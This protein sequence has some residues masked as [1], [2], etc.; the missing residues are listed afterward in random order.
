MGEEHIVYLNGNGSKVN[1]LAI[2][3][4]RE[5]LLKNP[6]GAWDEVRSFLDANAKEYICG[7][8]GYDL[9]ND[10]EKLESKNEVWVET[11]VV[12]LMVPT[13]IG[14]IRNGEIQTIKGIHEKVIS[15]FEE[16]NNVNRHS[17]SVRVDAS[18]DKKTYLEKI[19]KIKHHIHLGD[20]YEANFC[21]E[22]RG[23]GE[24]DPLKVYRNLNERTKAPFSV[25]AQ[26]NQLNVLCA[27]PERFIKK[28]GN[29]VFTQP[30]KGTIRR[31]ETDQMDL[32]LIE[33]LRNNPKDRSENI[34]I[35]DLVRNDLSRIAEP[36][37]VRVEELCEIYTFENVH[38][39]ISTVTAEVK[40][41]HPV[42]I[43]KALFPMGSM[44]GAP[45]IRAMELIEEYELSKRGLYSGCIGYFTPDGDF[46]FNVV[47]RTIIYDQRTG[48][49]SLSVGGAITDLSTPEGEYDETILKA[50]AL[51]E[52]LS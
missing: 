25:Y 12:Y 43:L 18:L 17:Q 32:Q 42:D 36:S 2:G 38:Q 39:M 51:K 40:E 3:C 22:Y 31:G 24:I 27:S 15:V 1:Y 4:E 45:K 47:I 46:D 49:I 37:S 48:R 21:Y 13:H 35:V 52:A 9:K 23:Q 29:R 10:I 19:K 50:K 14:M 16:L 26:I 7:W 20:I 33:E 44:T 34:M 6:V 41:K 8:L 30:I 5:L 11:P 28:E